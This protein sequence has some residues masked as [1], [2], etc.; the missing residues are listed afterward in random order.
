MKSCPLL[1][2]LDKYKDYFI[3][4]PALHAHKDMFAFKYKYM[5]AFEY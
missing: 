5:V 2:G 1:Y 4:I 3:N